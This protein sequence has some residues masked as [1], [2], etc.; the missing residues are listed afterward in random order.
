MWVCDLNLGPLEKQSILLTTEPF[1]QI[2]ILKS[3]ILMNCTFLSTKKNTR[4]QSGN[5]AWLQMLA[6]LA[7]VRTFS[8]F[9]EWWRKLDWW[10]QDLVSDSSVLESKG[11]GSQTCKHRGSET[12]PQ[13][14]KTLV[15]ELTTWI[16][17]WDHR[18]E[19]NWLQSCPDIHAACTY[20]YTINKLNVFL[21][22]IQSMKDTESEKISHK[23]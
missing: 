13:V 8:Q 9:P 7:C 1:C 15:T 20:I 12:A 21:K 10:T 3:S 16:P 19:E 14:K 17:S 11:R 18:V 23:K 4:Q 22:N 2:L 6:Y 5:L